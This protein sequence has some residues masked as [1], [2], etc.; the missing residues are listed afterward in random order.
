[1]AATT[2]PE[3][4]I[5]T[6]GLTVARD[7]ADRIHG[8][9]ILITGANLEGIGFSTAQAFASGSPAQLILCGRNPSKVQAVIDALKAE[10][11]AVD[12]RSLQVDLSRQQSVRA[13]A[14]TLLA[15]DDVPAVHI[16][17]NSA[18]IMCVPERTL[19][20]EGIELHFATNH[21][22]HWLLTNLIMPK[23]IKAAESSPR[24][25]V[26]IVNVSSRSPTGSGP[27]FSD[28]NFEVKNGD[29]PEEEKPDEAMFRFW[30]YEN[31]MDKA[32]LPLDGYSRSKVANVLFSVGATDRLYEKYGI[33]SI[34]L[35]PGII[36]TD[37]AR[38]FPESEKRA[39]E[40]AFA[41]GKTKKRPLSMGAST[42]LVAALD[43]K[44]KVESK[45]GQ[46]NYGVYLEDCQISDRARPAAV[47][48]Q[49]ADILWSLSEKLVGQTFSW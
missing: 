36:G 27:R 9:T 29:L 1:M 19:S 31:I 34:A 8:K 10:F 21:I 25:D 17:V 13:A 49:N 5:D 26:R 48:S 30:G 32:Y 35:H 47:S 15:W 12:Y 14:K 4:N 40:A 3:Y 18:G 38:A 6:E 37:L 24:G 7:F 42:S 2:H 20:E 46:E 11:P 39:M 33:L 44:L 16:V 22:G 28:I 41:S 45:P 23:L 43:P